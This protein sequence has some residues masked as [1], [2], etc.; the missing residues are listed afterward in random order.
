MS[1]K[2]YIHESFLFYFRPQK[3]N[4]ITVSDIIV[5]IVET[6]SGD[7]LL[8]GIPGT[9]TACG[10]EISDRDYSRIILTHKPN[11]NTMTN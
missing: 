4:G 11:P 6:E 3:T 7:K 1:S 8:V 2:P 10:L 5:N 9:E